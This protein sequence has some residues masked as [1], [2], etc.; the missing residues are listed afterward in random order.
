MTAK[1]FIF[2]G[3]SQVMNTWAEEK[4]PSDVLRTF[5][6]ITM[7]LMGTSPLLCKFGY[8]S[9]ICHKQLTER[10]TQTFLESSTAL[11]CTVPD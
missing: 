6:I 10:P 7:C 4:G 5:G 11:S 2:Y 8:T 9:S 3:F 1:N